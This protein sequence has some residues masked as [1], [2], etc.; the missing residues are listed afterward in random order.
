GTLGF[1][2]SAWYR[3]DGG[4]IDRCEPAVGQPGC[5]GILSRNANSSDAYALRLA[6]LWEP[7]E[8][9][10][11]TPS[12]FYQR[13]H[14][15]DGG[16]YENADSNPGRGQFVFGLASALPATDP[17]FIPS[18]KIEADLSGATLTS[19]TSY[20]WRHFDFQT[21]YTQYQDFAFFN[22]PYP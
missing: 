2:V 1:R 16:G 21:D 18:L 4:W 11:I 3:E 8:A 5:L 6:L 14:F 17:L 9:L 13:Q 19:V 22:N 10:R 20:V 15:D 7:N 12:L